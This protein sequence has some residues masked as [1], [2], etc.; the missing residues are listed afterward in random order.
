MF[1]AIYRFMVKPDKHDQFREGW[2]ILT[3][4]L[5][6]DNG[7]LGARMHRSHDG[8]WI[9]YAQWP[10]RDTW[11]RGEEVIAAFLKGTYWDEE[12]L[13]G[14]SVLFQLEPT[15]DLLVPTESGTLVVS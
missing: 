7:S 2:R 13:D 8:S 6:R 1:C 3:E 14:V 15:D 10:C 9:A 12:C 11:E 5:I 4:Q